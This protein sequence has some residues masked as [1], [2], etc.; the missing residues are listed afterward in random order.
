MEKLNKV[1]NDS[2]EM[3][4]KELKEKYS[5][6]LKQNKKLKRKL[7]FYKDFHEVN[8]YKIREFQYDLKSFYSNPING[9]TIKNV[10]DIFNELFG[11]Y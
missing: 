8:D 10:S 6:L 11:F 4:Q 3:N 7:I 5:R 9:L 2:L 1:E